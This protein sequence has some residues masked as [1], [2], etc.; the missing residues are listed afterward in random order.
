M[1]A[2]CDR[3][4]GRIPLAVIAPSVCKVVNWIVLFTSQ[5]DSP[6]SGGIKEIA[7]SLF[8]YLG[9]C[10]SIL[11]TGIFD[12]QELSDAPFVLASDVA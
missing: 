2:E 10:E 9:I 5:L 12:S 8:N 7:F 4:L 6:I 3:A 1:N 11:E